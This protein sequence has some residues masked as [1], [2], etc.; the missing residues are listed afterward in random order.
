MKQLVTFWKKDWQEMLRSG[1]LWILL[2]LFTLFGIMNP[3]MA[4]L[5]P[6]I[7]EM[8]AD[9]LEGS[10]LVITEVKVDALTSWAQYYKNVSLV[11]LVFF[12][13][14]SSILT[15][16]Y[17]K[18][19]LINMVTKGMVRWKI[20]VSKNLVLVLL[21]TLLYWV[22]YGITYGYNAY[23]WDNGIAENVFFGAFC[24]YILGLWLCSLVIIMSSVATTQSMVVLLTG[25]V[26]G[27]CYLVGMLSKWKE[28]LPTQLL[29]AGNLLSG[30]GGQKEYT[31]ALA[32]CLAWSLLNVLAAV[33]FFNK[34]SLV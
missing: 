30:N 27:G 19:T 15:V 5:T 9:S 34:K 6:W 10:G 4:K 23:F 14:I 33:L 28:Y 13:M 8:A 31:M 2:I 32:L 18:G 26:F 11:M 16:E 22:C 1:R 29:S 12:F 25:G 7:M 24:V 20:I 17:Q 3:A 21:W